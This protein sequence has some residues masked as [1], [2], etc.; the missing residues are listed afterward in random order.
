MSAFSFVLCSFEC[1]QHL[2]QYLAPSRCLINICW[3]KRRLFILIWCVSWKLSNLLKV[4]QQRGAGAR[5]WAQIVW[6]QSQGK[7]I[8]SIVLAALRGAD[9]SQGSMR[10]DTGGKG[11]WGPRQLE[12]IGENSCLAL[13]QSF[14]MKTHCRGCFL[15]PVIH[16]F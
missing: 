5:I 4:T 7:L 9:P 16:K 3:R 8:F 10:R 1:L 12:T 13:K 2:W 14:H 6:L 15:P 11:W